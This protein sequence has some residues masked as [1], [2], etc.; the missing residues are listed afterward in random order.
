MAEPYLS[1]IRLFSF[2]FAPTGWAACNGQLLPIN[3]NQA[4]FSLLGTTFG[5]DGTTTFAL[6]NLQGRV[7]VHVGEGITLGATGGS[8]TVALN[9]SQIPGHTHIVHAL[10]GP[11]EGEPSANSALAV[12]QIWG[13]P[14]NLV[15]LSPQSVTEIGRGQP[16]LNMQPY[17]TINFCIALTGLFPSQT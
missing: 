7:T 5:G 4:L 11:P 9:V 2:N 10:N 15:P 14:E 8:R 16:H 6:P 17:L 3:Q 12:A 1:E 13:E